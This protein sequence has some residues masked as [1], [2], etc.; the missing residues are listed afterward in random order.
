MTFQEFLECVKRAGLAGKFQYKEEW[1]IWNKNKIKI[2][3]MDKN[4]NLQEQ[5]IFNHLY[6]GFPEP[7]KGKYPK[8]NKDEFSRRAYILYNN[9]DK[10]D[11]TNFKDNNTHIKIICSIH[12]EFNCTPNN[13]LRGKRCKLCGIETLANTKRKKN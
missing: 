6:Y 2:K 5:T 1:F 4:D 8:L 9:I 12:G 7:K 11:L 13:Y 10:Y 3:F